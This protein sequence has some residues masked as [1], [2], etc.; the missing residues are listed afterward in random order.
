MNLGPVVSM[1]EEGATKLV[2][3]TLL[4]RVEVQQLS[5]TQSSSGC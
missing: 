1:F 3:T 4:L 5:A 2:S